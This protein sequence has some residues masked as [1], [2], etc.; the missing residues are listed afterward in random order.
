MEKNLTRLP[1]ITCIGFLIISCSGNKKADTEQVAA[2]STTAP[3]T[4][5]WISL[6]DGE[7]LNGW[8]R[9][10]ANDIG[11]LWKVEDGMIVCYSEGGG[12]ATSEGGSLITVEQFENF[13][14]T[15]DFKLSPSGNSGILYHVVEGPDY[16]HAY[17]T[18]PEYQLSDD[19]GSSSMNDIQ[20][21]AANYDMHAPSADKKL[22]PAGEWN[23][24]RIIYNNGHV[25]HWLNGEKVLE[26]EEG[27]DD[28]QAR[29]ENSKWVD[30]PGWCQYKKGSIALQDH[31]NHTWFRNIKVKKL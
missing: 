14:L 28:W 3:Q 6:F 31:G 27:S 30:Y 1:L 9:Y 22:N 10:N 20:K 23:T 18:G 17:V 24:A 4:E 8:K 29:Y 7:T 21:T 25:E 11:E 5:E 12:E 16:S 13:D 19:A 26:F 2:T 15:V